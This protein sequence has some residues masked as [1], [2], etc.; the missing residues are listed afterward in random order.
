[1]EVKVTVPHDL[2]VEEA[3][4]KAKPT[5][6]QC[7]EAFNGENIKAEWRGPNCQFSCTSMG[8][9]VDGH[10]ELRENEADVTVNL[11]L[12]ASMFKGRVQETVLKRLTGAFKKE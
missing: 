12:A 2:S 7:L 1:M 6:I 4:E 3:K 9:K 10:A 11:P 5:L 8:F